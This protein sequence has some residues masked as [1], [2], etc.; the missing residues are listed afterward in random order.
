MSLASVEIQPVVR[1][2]IQAVSGRDY[3][4]S[5][6]LAHDLD[7]TK[8]PYSKEEFE[9]TCVLETLPFFEHRALGEATL[10]LHRFGGTYGP[11]RFLLKARGT[12]GTGLVNVIFLNEAGLPL[13]HV[14]V[15]VQ[16]L[17]GT[18]ALLKSVVSPTTEVRTS[19]GSE[20][21]ATAR[22]ALLG[23]SGVGKT[24]LGWRIARGEYR[25]E[26]STHGQRFWVV[27][28]LSTTRDDGTKCEVVLWDLAGQPD[29]RL[30]HTLFLDRADLGLLVFDAT[31]RDRTLAGVEYWL[32][33]FRAATARTILEDEAVAIAGAPTLLIAARADLGVPTLT[34]AEIE[35][36]CRRQ[37]ISGYVATSARTAA[38]I[39][40]LIDL[41]KRALPWDR[42]TAT[43]T[44]RAFKRMREHILKLKAS[45][46]EMLLLPDEELRRQ[47]E[48]G[49]PEWH[50]T[51]GEMMTALGHL[52]THGY[53]ARL[54]RAN[55]EEATLL[56]P[57][58][59][60]NVASSIVLE[61]R[62]DERGLGLV[63][64]TRLLAGDY[65]FHELD[66]LSRTDQATLLD[67]GA[68][69]FL[70]RK[71]CFR[72]NLNSRAYL[73][74]PSL[75]NQRR[76]TTDDHELLDDVSYHV[77][78]AVETVYP[79]LVVEL[80]YT[81]LFRSVARWQNEA[82]YEV[83][84]GEICGFRQIDEREGEIELVLSYSPGAGSDTRRRFQDTIERFLRRRPL[85]ISRLPMVACMKGHLQLREAI[86]TA[87]YS[88][89]KF[90][91]CSTCGNKI[92]TPQIAEIGLSTDTAL[93]EVEERADQRTKYE[94]A[95]A[96]AKAF[97]RDRGDGN[98]K[99]SCLISY[100]WGDQLH[101]Q[102][103]EHLADYLQNA[104]VVV[105]LDR[106]HTS[107][108]V[109][110]DRFLE[111]IA[112]SDFVCAVGTPKYRQRDQTR[113][114]DPVVEAELRLIKSKLSTD[115]IPGSVIALLCAG[116][117]KDSFPTLFKHSVF[118]DFRSEADFFLRLFELVL[119][120]HRIPFEDKMAHHH[121]DEL[122]GASQIRHRRRRGK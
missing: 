60:I 58:L 51:D 25:E 121:R 99:P 72:E 102:W 9:I 89:R 27:D 57:D 93:R 24:G 114:T 96:W 74:F 107:P 67:T 70:R 37:G 42:L 53:V 109:R 49:D 110:M 15:Q 23:D 50:F 78:G 69:L 47:L 36:F 35:A 28:Q 44:T 56:M 115:L 5:V 41:I 98:K 32:R 33:H 116:T 68:S 95:V 6:D 80:G 16:I 105:T 21:Y 85:E 48:A 111:R 108:D 39:A 82:Q 73:V 65:R 79:A 118:L 87:V 52:E 43:T 45:G 3:I 18:E 117:M 66:G 84:P 34:V 29:Y 14:E 62:R 91:F 76:P 55:G 64:E 90:F 26:A 86:R 20:S 12:A 104:D 54:Q 11:V 1:L 119:T 4:G 30:I 63:D 71:L 97:R 59:L 7:P 40:E 106:W 8:W 31:N 83:E 13:H 112:G 19:E 122:N 92:A 100:A 101:E 10:I 94:V 46:R 38:G 17:D 113:D 22:I 61:G 120:I 81:N 2:P 77:S 88:S 75:I 103:V